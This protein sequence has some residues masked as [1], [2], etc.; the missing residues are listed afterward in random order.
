MSHYV[1]AVYPSN[2][3]I[4]VVCSCGERSSG[5]D[6]RSARDK[7]DTHLEQEAA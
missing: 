4:R 7:H 2:G 5:F 1:V 3:Q 6:R